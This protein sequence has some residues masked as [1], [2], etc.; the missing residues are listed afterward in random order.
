M[1]G[2]THINPWLYIG[3]GTFPNQVS[4]DVAKTSLSFTFIPL[5]LLLSVD[6]TCYQLNQGLG[7]PPFYELYGALNRMGDKYMYS[8]YMRHFGFMYMYTTL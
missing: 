4:V 6:D 5:I 8:S 3:R 2:T 7:H 1:G